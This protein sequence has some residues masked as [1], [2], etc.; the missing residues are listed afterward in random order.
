MASGDGAVTRI[1]SGEEGSHTSQVFL[2]KSPHPCGK[3]KAWTLESSPPG[4]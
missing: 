2:S 3:A 4:F 1:L